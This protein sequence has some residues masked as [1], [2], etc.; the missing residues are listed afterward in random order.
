MRSGCAAIGVDLVVPKASPHPL[1]RFVQGDAE[2]LPLEDASIDGALCECALCT[3]PNKE[4]AARELARVLRPGTRLALS[5]VTAEPERLPAELA[6]VEAW[7][8]CVADARPLE[9]IAA[10]LEQAGLTVEQSESH[11]RELASLLER[12]EARLRAVR[13]LAAFDVERALELCAAARNAVLDGILG[14]SV[15]IA[16]R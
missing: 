13:V 5:D 9:E 11:D 1:V 10:L 12:V 2:A 6:T 3:F 4:Q 14:Y 7:V 15:V 16:R 8:A